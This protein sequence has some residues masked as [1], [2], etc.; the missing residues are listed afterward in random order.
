MHSGRLLDHST[1]A[2][3][4]PYW[5]LN[6]P[7]HYHTRV[8]SFLD[9]R[10]LGRRC[11]MECPAGSPD[12]TSLDFLWGHLKSNPTSSNVSRMLQNPRQVGGEHFEQYICFEF[13]LNFL[14]IITVFLK[15][16]AVKTVTKAATYWCHST[17]ITVQFFKVVLAEEGVK[18][19]FEIKYIC[20]LLNLN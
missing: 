19:G 2:V 14:F 3:R 6:Y 16:M 18:I 17:L 5:P 11:P 7:A 12:L 20:F 9:A 10:F 8:R 13:E 1:F 15:N 4:R